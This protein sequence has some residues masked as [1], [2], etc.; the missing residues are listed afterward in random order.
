M[1]TGDYFLIFYLGFA[2]WAIYILFI[3]TPKDKNKQ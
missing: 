1:T 3:Y 2:A